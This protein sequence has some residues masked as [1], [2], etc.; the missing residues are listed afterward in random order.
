MYDVLVIG[1]GP[2]GYPCAIR[3]AQSGLKVGLVES[4]ELGGVCLNKGCIPT[5][6]LFTVSCEVGRQG[7]RSIDKTV[8][9]QWEKILAEIKTDVVL[10]LRTGVAFLLKQHKIDIYQGKG[11]LIGTDVVQIRDKTISCRNIVIATGGT[12]ITP[13]I[14]RDSERTLTSDDLWK[15]EKLPSSIAIVG[16]GVIGCEFASI[17][18][19]FGVKV[20]IYE[21]KENLLP[22]A[23]EEITGLLKKYLEKR[24]IRIFTGKKIE[25]IN[26]IEE[27]KILVTVG[28]QASI[29]DTEDIGIVI[30]KGAIKTDGYMKTNINNIYAVGDVNGKYQL[31]Y[32]ATREGEIAARNINGSDIV[33]DY[34]HIPSTVFT[35]PEI[36]FCGITEKQALSK[37]LIIK[38]GRFPYTA[39]GKAYTQKDTEGLVKVIAD[40][41]TQEILG[42][43]MIGRGST[44]LVS[45]STLAINNKLKIADLEKI[46]YCHPTYAEGI[47]EAVE[48][49][50]K[51]SIHLPPDK[52]LL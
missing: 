32:T 28:R 45:F 19:R 50:N 27:E 40:A 18:N 10:R 41:Q 8:S 52:H 3:C 12:P 26:T 4:A 30:E 25:T 23:D 37:G 35:D 36:S 39:L 21:M 20:S 16:G 33:M 51:K 34:S 46:L 6:A 13:E 17:F 22:E 11:K 2:A 5:K 48:D 7:F 49:V 29:P 44:E 14:C 9:Y 15:M 42:I 38:T 1:A 43:H 47:I 31:A 24:G